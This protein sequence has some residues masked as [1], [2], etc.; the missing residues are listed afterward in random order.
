MNDALV[1]CGFEGLSDLQ[2]QLQGLAHRDRTP[3][4]TL[5]QGLSLNQL[6]HEQLSPVVFFQTMDRRDVGVIQRCQQAG[7][8]LETGDTVRVDSKGRRQE[9]EGDLPAQLT[10]PGTVDLTHPPLPDEGHHRVGAERRPALIGLSSCAISRATRFSAGS[11]DNVPDSD[12]RSRASISRRNSLSSPHPSSS[13]R[14]RSP[15][16]ASTTR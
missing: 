6:E 13:S 14:A 7:F 8:T 12:C 1:V 2:S 4:E 10:V 3:F 9:L 5:S 16:G 15:A 11:W